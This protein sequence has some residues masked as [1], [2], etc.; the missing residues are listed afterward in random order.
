MKFRTF[1]AILL[2]IPALLVTAGGG[3][4][5]SSEAGGPA[6]VALILPGPIEDADFN[7]LG[8]Q[9]MKDI[10]VQHGAETA[11]QERVTPADSE[12]VA[13]AFIADGYDTVA[14]HGGQFTTTLLKLADQF[15]DNHFAIVTR[16]PIDGAPKNAWVIGRRWSAGFYAFGILAARATDTD[17]IGVVAGIALPDWI[18][19]INSIKKAAASIDSDISV[20]STFTGDQNDSV[21]ARNATAALVDAGADVI[22][23]LVNGGTFGSIQAVEGSD[24]KLISFYTDKQELADDNMVGS[25]IFDFS[26]AYGSV[27]GNIIDGQSGGYHE[28]RPG[29]GMEMTALFNVSDEVAEEAR[30]VFDDIA[31]GKIVVPADLTPVE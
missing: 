31:S 29:S 15:P 11:Y 13:R 2:V 4:E 3:G 27:V 26:H 28:M 6:R 10:E 23:L 30:M 12:R 20:L 9:A 5:E 25:L 21:A 22:I 1:L 14:F 16:A 8:Y 18:E 17:T 7:Y 24:V 19:A